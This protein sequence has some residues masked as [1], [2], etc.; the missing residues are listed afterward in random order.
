[1]INGQIY[2]LIYILFIFENAAHIKRIHLYLKTLI[3]K[4]LGSN[5]NVF[6]FN[7]EW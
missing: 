3:R 4:I 6:Y 2:I 5:E 1:M 7:L